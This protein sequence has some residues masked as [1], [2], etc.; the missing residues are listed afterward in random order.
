MNTPANKSSNP[1]NSKTQGHTPGPWLVFATDGTETNFQK[2]VATAAELEAEIE[3][4]KEYTDGNWRTYGVLVSQSAAAP[5]LLEACKA[6]LKQAEMVNSSGAI[7]VTLSSFN[8]L[9]VIAK[10]EG[11]S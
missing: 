8:A 9:S 11:R 3:H 7:N 10:A 4:T 5:E 2:W 1:E 6:L